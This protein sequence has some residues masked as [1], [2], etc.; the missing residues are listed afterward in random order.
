MPVREVTEEIR[1]TLQGVLCLMVDDPP[2]VCVTVDVNE[3]GVSQITIVVAPYDRGK[4]IGSG[5]RVARSL[6]IILRGIARQHKLL[7]QLNI[8]GA[9]E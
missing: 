2:H 8:P 9:D 6:R 5:G 4:V 1:Q 3:L 7:L